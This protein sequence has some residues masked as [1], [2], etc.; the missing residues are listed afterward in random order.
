MID[1]DK[2]LSRQII[3]YQKYL[4]GVDDVSQVVR[5]DVHGVIVD[6]ILDGGYGAGFVD[7]FVDDLLVLL[8]LLELLVDD[9]VRDDVV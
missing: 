9:M 7:A 1:L 5:I 2:L 4:E 8:E 6:E 3:Y